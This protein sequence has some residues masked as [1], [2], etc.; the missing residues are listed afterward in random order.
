MTAATSDQANQIAHLTNKLT[1]AHTQISSLQSNLAHTHSLLCTY[2]ASLG[3]VTARV[4]Q[5]AY[6]NQN[7][8]IS[9]HAHYNALLEQSR[10]ETIQAQLIH[11]EWQS[12]LLGLSKNLR[13]AQRALSDGEHKHM[14]K[15][16]GLKSENAVLRRLA[17]WEEAEETDDDESSSDDEGHDGAAAP[18]GGNRV[19]GLDELGR[20][21]NEL[22]R[23]T[24]GLTE[25]DVVNGGMSAEHKAKLAAE[26][27]S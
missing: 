5:H 11:Q 20:A 9:I 15:I 21:G 17:G 6:D 16:H 7:H 10:N 13:A 4:R 2:E 19:K 3:D 12:R 25:A 22:G 24:Q 23:V 8:I 18:F 26:H 14:R 1:S 27:N